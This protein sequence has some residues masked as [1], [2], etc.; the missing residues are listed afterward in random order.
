M[1]PLPYLILITL[2]VPVQTHLLSL[3]PFSFPLDLI[4][5]IT[6]YAGYFSGKTRGMF[7]GAYLGLLTDVLSGELLGTQMFLKTL[8]GYMAAVFGF[9]IFSKNLGIHFLLLWII[10]LLN[11]VLNLFFLNLFREGVPLQEALTT[12]ILPAAF[13]NALFGSLY[14]F[15][16]QRRAH[17]RQVF[18]GERNPE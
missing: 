6:F 2:A 15:L 11:G 18:A 3:L 10:S 4:L 5:V 17:N 14:V 1:K 12:L 7:T 13:W 9:G 16:N 8:T